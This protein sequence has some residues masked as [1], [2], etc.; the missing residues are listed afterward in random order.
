MTTPHSSLMSSTTESTWPLSSR[1]RAPS[2]R[3]SSAQA[4]AVRY[5]PWLSGGATLTG[6]ARAVT[7]PAGSVATK[8]TAPAGGEGKVTA[9]VPS[10]STVNGSPSAVRSTRS[11]TWPATVTSSSMPTPSG[12]GTSRT[13]GVS[14]TPKV[15]VQVSEPKTVL[16]T[17]TDSS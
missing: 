2:R 17:S 8:S 7:L 12:A 13:G 9:K 3:P 5:S 16:G 6:T 1:A 4:S 15:M 11:S 14:S 10:S